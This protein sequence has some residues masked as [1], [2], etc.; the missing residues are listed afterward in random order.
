MKIVCI[1]ALYHPNTK[2][3]HEISRYIKYPDL[4]LLL[5]DSETSNQQLVTEYLSDFSDQYSYLWNEKNIGLCASV[6]RGIAYA[7]ERKADWILLM[8]PDSAF[9]TNILAAFRKYIASHETENICALAPQYNYDRHQRQPYRGTRLIKWANMSGTLLNTRL[10][11]EIGSYDERLFID[12]LDVEWCTRARKM[13]YRIIEIGEA[14]LY[15]HPAFTREFSVG[16]KVLFRYGWDK[17]ER[18]YY[19]F[20][21]YWYII[22]KYHDIDSVKW[23]LIK[24]CK[25]ILLFENKKEYFEMFMKGVRD[26]KRENWGKISRNLKR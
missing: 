20:R 23:F 4:T 18:Y 21:S 26:V 6:N 13:G 22:K 17:P 9:E 10:L 15:H 19:Q 1:V 25:V 5:D 24:L 2:E 11:K 3:L 12:G 14:V 7:I 8:N 16:N